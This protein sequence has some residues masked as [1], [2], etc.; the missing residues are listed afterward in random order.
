MH[1][2]IPDEILFSVYVSETECLSKKWMQ[3]AHAGIKIYIFYE[4]FCKESFLNGGKVF[5]AE[6]KGVSI[7]TLS[8]KL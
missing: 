6:N 1:F 7:M 8:M 2:H 5:L 4:N 3:M